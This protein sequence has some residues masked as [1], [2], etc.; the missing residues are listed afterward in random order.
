MRRERSP[1][2]RRPLARV[3]LVVS[4]MPPILQQNYATE[5]TNYFNAPPVFHIS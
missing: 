4:F 1:F 5:K 3:F 2:Q